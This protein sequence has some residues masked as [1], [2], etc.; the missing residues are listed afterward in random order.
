MSCSFLRLIQCT[1][2]CRQI[3][4]IFSAGSCSKRHLVLPIFR[5]AAVAQRIKSFR[6]PTGQKLDL[7]VR[8][9]KQCKGKKQGTGLIKSLFPVFCARLLKYRSQYFWLITFLPLFQSCKLRIGIPQAISFP[10]PRI[11]DRHGCEQLAHYKGA[12]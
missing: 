11:P 6:C 9:S 1:K 8:S 3:R 12:G 4:N 10:S 7:L 2:M 5:A